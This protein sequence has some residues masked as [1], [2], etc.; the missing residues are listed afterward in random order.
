MTDLEHLTAQLFVRFGL[1]E[2]A[3]PRGK[4]LDHSEIFF[5]AYTCVAGLLSSDGSDGSFG[6]DNDGAAAE[7]EF[8]HVPFVTIVAELSRAGLTGEAAR[9]KA[10]SFLID[11]FAPGLTWVVV[12]ELMDKGGE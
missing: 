11:Y 9:T 3:K 2:L 10:R 6:P 7:R 12:L 8:V 4:Q 1:E 5:E